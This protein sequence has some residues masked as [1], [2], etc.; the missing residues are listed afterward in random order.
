MFI[1]TALAIIGAYLLISMWSFGKVQAN[2]LTFLV[3]EYEKTENFEVN[4]I[5]DEGR[6]VN[7]NLSPD[8]IIDN[9]KPTTHFFL[10]TSF[11]VQS[12][13][14]DVRDFYNPQGTEGKMITS[15]LFYRDSNNEIAIIKIL[16]AGENAYNLKNSQS[17]YCIYIPSNLD[18]VLIQVENITLNN[19]K[20]GYRTLFLASVISIYIVAWAFYRRLA[21]SFSS[22]NTHVTLSPVLFTSPRLIQIIFYG[23]SLLLVI[24]YIWCFLKLPHII[25]PEFYGDYPNYAMKPD[26]PFFS[27]FIPKIFNNRMIEMGYYRP[28]ILAFI[29]QYIDTNLTVLINS[30]IPQFGLRMPLALAIIPVSM[31]T[32]TYVIK[33]LFPYLPK[34]VGCFVA[35]LSL[36]LPNIL[37]SSFL[38][39]RSAKIIAPIVSIAIL[40]YTL[41]KS[42]ENFSYPKYI[43]SWKYN[44]FFITILW[45][46]CTFD[47]QLI[48]MCVFCI[49][50][51]LL[52]AL[53]DQKL[54]TVTINFMLAVIAYVIYHFTWGRWLFAYFTPGGLEKHIHTFSMLLQDFN[55]SFI[56]QTVETMLEFLRTNCGNCIGILIVVMALV[57][58]LWLHIDNWKEKLIALSIFAFSFALSL[59]IL[60]GLPILYYYKDMVNGIYFIEP[61]LTC[62]YGT[63]YVIAKSK[64]LRRT[65]LK[66]QYLHF[67]IVIVLLLFISGLNISKM[68]ESHLR[69][70]GINGGMVQFRREFIDS[71]YFNDYYSSVIVTRE[72]Y[73]EYRGEK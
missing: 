68:E 57:I 42:N 5:M 23:M 21:N 1:F 49:A 12:V 60:I 6:L 73:D 18:Q 54:K 46:L 28:R 27:S 10:E 56:S 45:W 51:S 32:W 16:S 55:F 53:C 17:E 66:K 43:K 70:L 40:S 29:W 24:Y 61:L 30:V 50:L 44:C 39:L 71:R 41:S 19:F 11:I 37:T 35:S 15:H 59:A 72:Q 64:I 34:G 20:R 2:P 14:V 9:A 38:I 52:I 13:I 8:G 31:A 65:T 7:G 25:H 62:M 3:G 36:Y 47:E 4:R 22:S 58:G 67:G 69:T 63:F 33:S 26:E 48:A